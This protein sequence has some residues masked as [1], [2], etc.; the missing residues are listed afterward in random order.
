LKERR[1]FDEVLV[2]KNYYTRR[3]DRRVKRGEG[4]SGEKG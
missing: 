1:H 3:V 2:E 4:R